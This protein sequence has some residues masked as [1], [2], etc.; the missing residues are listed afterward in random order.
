MHLLETTHN[1]REIMRSNEKEL[2]YRCWERA[3]VTLTMCFIN[4]SWSSRRPAVSYSDW[5][6]FTAVFVSV[7]RDMP[8]TL[9]AVV[10]KSSESSRNAR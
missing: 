3:F 8:D 10:P 4:S 2:S 6:D 1:R 9:A 7:N 5:L